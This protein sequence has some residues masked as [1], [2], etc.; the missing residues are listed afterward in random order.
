MQVAMIGCPFRTSYGAY[1]E[2]LKGALERRTGSKVQ[3]IGSNCGCGDPI[4]VS[5][6]FQTRD[7]K[8]FEMPHIGESFS[9]ISWKRYLRSGLRS[10]LYYFRVFRYGR[11]ADATDLVHLQQILNA[12]GS[13]V[14]FHWLRQR[15]DSARV[16]TIHELDNE[17]TD[18]QARNRTYNRTDAIIVHD[19]ELK[20]KLVSLEVDGHLIHVIRYGTEIPATPIREKREGLVF[21]G[22]HK[23]MSG[24]GIKAVF[25]ALAIV[26]RRLGDRAPRL[27]IHGHYG[28]QTPAEALALAR[29]LGVEGRI[30]WLNQISMEDMARLYRTSLLCLLPFTGSFAGLPA[31]VAAANELPI[32]CTRKAGIPDHIGDCGVWVSE[33]QP[34][35]LADRAIELLESDA[36]RRNY[37]AR[38]RARAEQCLSWDVIAQETYA[39]YESAR[40]R[41]AN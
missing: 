4:E 19:K 34:E 5:R 27:R 15:S 13:V 38:L 37:G 8:Y 20:E 6:S 22:G 31:S 12:T 9:Q 40:Q 36:L 30:D 39:V 1:I 21:Y 25:E 28:T 23:L 2:S 17:Q 32:V 24:K 14:A 26:A 29:T 18:D 41:R 16:V 33:N 7:C 35:E 11:L 3:W 10:S